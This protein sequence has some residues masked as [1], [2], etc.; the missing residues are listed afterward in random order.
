MA[1]NI[2]YDLAFILFPELQNAFDEIEAPHKDEVMNRVKNLRYFMV[3]A[4]DRLRNASLPSEAKEFQEVFRYGI[5]ALKHGFSE[6]DW[7]R[8][9]FFTEILMETQ[10]FRNLT[11]WIISRVP[12]IE[13]P[14]IVEVDPLPPIVSTRIYQRTSG[15]VYYIDSHFIS[16]NP[17]MIETQQEYMRRYMVTGDIITSMEEKFSQ[18][19]NADMYVFA[20]IESWKRGW[21]TLIGL[22]EKIL[23]SGGL[24]VGVI[25]LNDKEG[26]KTLMRAWQVPD[27]PT[28]RE[29]MDILKRLRY[30]RIRTNIYGPFMVFM[31]SKR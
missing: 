23:A 26:L 20:S 10:L 1:E 21:D 29:V 28:A 31:A 9:I 24:L 30:T 6:D 18:I 22:A 19:E 14:K 11:T 7:R 27:F 15:E 8:Y 25:P 4:E 12:I 16:E 2:Y 5:T 13:N 17:V 3:S